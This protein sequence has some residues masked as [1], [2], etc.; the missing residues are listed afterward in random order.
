MLY[1][2]SG[3]HRLDLNVAVRSRFESWDAF[4]MDT[5]G[6]FGT[7]ESLKLQSKWRDLLVLLGEVQDG[8]AGVNV[9]SGDADPTDGDHQTFFNV[10]PSNHIYYGFAD[11]IDLPNLVDPFV[12]LRLTPHPMLALNLFAHWFRLTRD[13]DSR[14]SGT[15]VFNKDSFGFT[16]QPSRGFT[17]VGREYDAVATI[18]P[19]RA[20]AL[21][22]G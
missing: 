4:A 5:D 18:T 13:S 8:R 20:L 2:R 14:Y 11:Q 1:W 12:Q 19:H 9:G 22:V 7:R 16:A 17:H 3:G 6:F 10:L 15:A 21:E